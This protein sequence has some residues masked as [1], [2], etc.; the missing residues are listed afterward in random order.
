MAV[1]YAVFWLVVM[2]EP[3]PV[4]PLIG[5]VEAV[6]LYLVHQGARW[7]RSCLLLVLSIGAVELMFD[8]YE[9]HADGPD[10]LELA[11][12]LAYGASCVLLLLPSV[13][14]FMRHRRLASLTPTSDDRAEAPNHDDSP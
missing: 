3:G 9:A 8:A 6:L 1:T 2:Y 11:C 13:S 14:A 4:L 10:T 12:G 5:L 7:A